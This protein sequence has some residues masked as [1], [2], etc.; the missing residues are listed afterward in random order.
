MRILGP[1][2]QLQ[3]L[4]TTLIGV[5]MMTIITSDLN[6]QGTIAVAMKIKWTSNINRGMHGH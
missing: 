6:V 1:Q 3:P 4:S 2:Q 5:R